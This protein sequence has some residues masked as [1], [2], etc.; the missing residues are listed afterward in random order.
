ML[1]TLIPAITRKFAS[2]LPIFTDKK[3]NDFA[4]ALRNL[5]TDVFLPGYIEKYFFL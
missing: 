3:I 4:Q 1:S 2:F 5:F